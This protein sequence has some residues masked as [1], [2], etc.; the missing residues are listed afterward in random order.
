MTADANLTSPET[1]LVIDIAHTHF[2]KGLLF[3]GICHME[4]VTDSCG[5]GKKRHRTQGLWEKI[6]LCL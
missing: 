4:K 6:A 5:F 1:E 3:W 2:L